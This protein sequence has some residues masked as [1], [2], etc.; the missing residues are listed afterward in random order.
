MTL[1]IARPNDGE[2]LD[3]MLSDS[4]LSKTSNRTASSA[5]GHPVHLPLSLF[6]YYLTL[7][8]E[9]A[10]PQV[11]LIRTAVR[12][13]VSQSVSQ[14]VSRD[15]SNLFY[16]RAA[17]R[18]SREGTQ[19][20]EESYTAP[21]ANPS[22]QSHYFQKC[23]KNVTLQISLLLLGPSTFRNISLDAVRVAA[24]TPDGANAKQLL[25]RRWLYDEDACV[26]D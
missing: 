16:Q 14:A 17:R 24:T 4:S 19:N 12:H 20:R 7:A 23:W 13:S 22:I 15:D 1:A 8:R 5:K 6:R 25:S 10:R 18:H 9:K 26:G 11:S 2:P 21:A 3:S